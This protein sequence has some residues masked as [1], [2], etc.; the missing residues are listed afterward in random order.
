MRNPTT[1][2]MIGTR[3]AQ[4][5]ITTH[6]GSGGMGDVYQARDT[7]LGRS[8]AIKF[9]PSAFSHD[10]ER[11]ARFRREARVLASLN[12]PNIAAI[13]GFDEIEGRHLLVME[14][15]TGETLEERTRRGA[16]SVEEALPIAKQIAEAL[17]E[18]HEAGIVH[19]DLK[20]ANIK[21]TTGD[22]VKV[23]DFGLAKAYH[24]DQADQADASASTSPTITIS[25]TAGGVILGTAAYM[26]PEQARGKPVDRR[27][28]IWA[29][30]VVLFR[31]L[32]GSRVFEGETVSDTLANVIQREPDWGQLPP[33]TPPALRTLLQRCLTKNPKNRLQAIGDARIALEEL[34]EHRERSQPAPATPPV[35]RWQ[36]V[37]PWAL[38]PVCL[39]AGFL[40]NSP[41]Q[42]A[43]QPVLQF[44]F[45]LPSNHVLSHVNRHAV[46]L[47]ADGRQLAYVAGPVG[48]ATGRIYVRKLDVAT[49][50]LVPD[51]DGARSVFFSPDG[52]WIGFQQR[53]QIKKVSLAGA[54][55]AVI[56]ENLNLPG[57]DWGPPG[58][59]WG[60]N[61]TIVFPYTLG[62]GLS[63]VRDTG[64]KPE[65][66]T[67]LDP[68]NHEVSHRLPHFLPD[69]S[70][71]LFTVLRYTAV[72][73]DWSRGQVWVK[74]LKN[75][76]RKLLLDNALDAQYAGENTLVFARQGKL[77]AIRFDPS[78]MS[79]TGKEV[80]VLDGVTHS[81]YGTAAIN[82]TGVA[83]FSVADG[84]TLVYAP[85]SI[86][87]PNVSSLIW[88]DRRGRT[89]PITNMRGMSRFAPRVLPDGIR[90][91]SS[92]LY[93]NK[94]IWIFDTARGTEDRITYEGQNAFPI[95]TADGSRFA[96][97][98]DRAGPQQIYVSDAANPTNAKPLTSGPFDVPSAWTP[99]GKELLFTRGFTSLGGNTDIYA[100][101][102]DRPDK[103][104]ALIATPAEERFPELSPDGKW[105]AYVSNDT[106]Q[107]QLYVQ[108]YP[109]PGPRVTIASGGAQDPAWSKN[110]SELFYA[111]FPGPARMMAVPFNVSGGSFVP[112][113]PVELFRPPSLGSGT[114]VRGTYDVAPDGRFLLN[115]VAPEVRE[116][117]NRRIFPSTLRI[118]LNWT[119]AV[120]RLLSSQ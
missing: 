3:L 99:D 83:Q 47:S 68:A 79:V 58:I 93:A 88:F 59:V 92:E 46:A 98:S 62:S 60:R 33:R 115:Q 48:G 55:P 27:A 118:V 72:T 28:D 31:L 86:E 80:Q 105:L 6:L 50:T 84:G 87:P 45:P 90:I 22:K 51:T 41:G 11:V 16:L 21:L 29:F 67:A 97:R 85:G 107:P 102:I 49:D 100:V 66:L 34:I 4:Y 1:S 70:G 8:V 37:L 64:G 111:A 78:S 38:V 94:D 15:A 25:A 89:N 9:L 56:V 110:S 114:T 69:G 57:A 12:H 112:G 23:L 96:F 43:D 95:W 73:P 119:G 101:S 81:M 2:Q 19:R 18:A 117:R 13:Y 10:V 54:A 82:W 44:D 76:E 77:F 109:G 35:P 65:E 32:T 71:V 20:P 74:S 52:N 7:R 113:E 104:R 26:A 24:V 91:A 30:G 116:E 61:G 40:L 106:G 120:Q 39:T 17:E 53:Q 63:M 103:P 14:L 75:G 5:E 108:P 36:R 42:P